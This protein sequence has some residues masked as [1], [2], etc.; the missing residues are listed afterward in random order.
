MNRKGNI[1]LIPNIKIHSRHY[2]YMAK[3]FI[4]ID[5]STLKIY[6][7]REKKFFF[8]FLLKFFICALLIWILQCHYNILESQKRYDILGLGA[9]RSLA[10]CKDAIKQKNKGLK[11]YDQQDIIEINL[12]SNNDQKEIE[13]NMSIEKGNEIE[14]TEKN[15]KVEVNERIL[16]ICKNNLKLFLSFFAFLLSFSSCALY[17]LNNITKNMSS[18]DYTVFHTLA[19]S[20]ISILFIYEKKKGKKI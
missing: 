4:D 17:A 7:K 2:S 6:S 15:K 16:G 1:I 9:K 10:E 5:M 18:I 20:L 13:Y 3:S 12:E 11:C 8:N 14:E 19:L